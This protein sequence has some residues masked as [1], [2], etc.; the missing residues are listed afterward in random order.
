MKVVFYS[1]SSIL[2][3]HFGI[4]LDEAN[5]FADQGDSVVFVTCSRYNDV[6]LKNPSG[7]RGLCYICNQTNYIGLRN[8]RASVIQKKLSNYYTK[9]QS[10]KFDGYKSL[11]DIKKIDYKGGLIGYAAIS[12]YVTVTRNINPKIDDIFY[13]Y[14]N[15]I[16]EQEVSLIDTFQK[17]IDFEKPDLVCLFNGRFFENRPLYDLC[18]GNNITVRTYEFD[19]G[20][21]EKFI[22]LYFENA[23]PHNLIINT[24][25]A[26][27]C[28]NNSKDCDRI[29]KEKAKSFFEK[30]RNGIIA[31]DKVYIENQIKGKL[32]IDWDDTKRNIA[33]FNSS[34]DE[35]IAVDRDFDN[36]S[37]YKS[38]IDGI[39]GIFEHY[40][41]NQTVHF[42][43]RVHPNLK[44]VHY[45]YHLLLYDLSLKYPNITVIGADSDISTY[46]IMDNAEKVI[47]F[48]STM[49]LES[50]YW[51][52]PV[53]LLSG[54]FYY[55]MNVC[56]IPKSK[57]ELWTL[58]DDENLKPFADKQNT[59]VMG[60]Y[61][62]DRSFRPNI[63][64]QTK[65]DYNPSY[66]KIF[67]WKIKLYPYLRVCNSKFLFKLMFNISIYL[68]SYIS[69]CKYVIPKSENEF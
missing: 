21:E 65:L 37:L 30:R 6:C 29:K 15:S 17:L 16:L 2:N 62:L 66:I 45:Q 25:Y 54:S 43:L 19:G 24:N 55:Y 53:I 60:Y 47:V 10:V 1:T 58:I 69:S 48:G 52:K 63:I 5:R 40:K 13:A 51:G 9:K 38:Q 49:G 26:F 36:L 67:K 64:H 12:S 33:I 31:G 27:E 57:N 20:R 4:L 34:E 39:R 8:L 68:C 59:L 46:D 7:N 3:P 35:F 28:W 56:Y 22:K 50:S 42:Y 11:D 23:L 44:N 18:I 14:F 41:E 61:F 32:P